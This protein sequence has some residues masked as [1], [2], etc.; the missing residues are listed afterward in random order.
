MHEKRVKVSFHPGGQCIEVPVGTTILAAAR[1]AGVN[2]TAPCGGNKGCGRCLVKVYSQQKENWLLACR[3]V[4]VEELLVELNTQPPIILATGEGTEVALEPAITY[5]VRGEL[6]HRRNLP[7]LPQEQPGEDVLGLAVDV[8]TTTLVAYL[9]NLLDG[10]LLAVHSLVN[11][12]QIFGADVISRLGY[13]LQG[14]DKYRQ[15]RQRLLDD[16]NHLAESCCRAAET[17]TGLVREMVLVGNTAMMHFFL[18]LPIEGL[19]VAPF[20]PR[21]RGSCYRSAVELGL[22]ALPRAV[23][24]VPP[25]IGSFVGSDALAAALA[26]DFGRQGTA[27]LVDIGTNGEILLQAGERLL[28]ASV[29][30]GPALEG[31]GIECGMVAAA[32]AISKVTIDFDVH[33][34]VIGGGRATGICGSGLVDALA[35]MLRLGIIDRAG[36]LL[37]PSQVP[38]VVSF[39]VKQRLQQV[40]DN[41]SFFLTEQV[42]ISQRDIRAVQ[43]AKAAV[44]AG[45]KLLLREAGLSKQALSQILLAGGFGT[46]LNP[47]NALRIGLL[48]KTANTTKL[49][50]VGNAA[51]VGAVLLLLSYPARQRAEQLSQKFSHYELATNAHFQTVFLEQMAFPANR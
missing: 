49:Q 2:L 28:A 35:E 13:A 48:G 40:G 16:I 51:G 11:G 19:A 37:P 33:T 45:I 17:R 3:T 15:L 25:I 32:G 4:V 1:L 20:K 24:Y 6:K 46:Y 8:G 50:Q 30:A 41:I 42:Y 29:P 7:L 39:K 22:T 10:R 14:A 5:D 9:Y 27:L 26:Q 12:Q 31:A 43:L 47:N 23:C 34:E 21:Q 38:P 44:A 18:D 36:Q